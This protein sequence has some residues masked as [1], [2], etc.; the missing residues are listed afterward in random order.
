MKKKSLS[1]TDYLLPKSNFLTGFGTVI[2][3]FGN[4]FSYNYSESDEAADA[5]AIYSDWS[6][7]G[8]DIEKSKNRFRKKS[9]ED[10]CLL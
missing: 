3:I 10:L 2:N 8:K 7:V 9:I 1:R 5:K 6:V 4:Y